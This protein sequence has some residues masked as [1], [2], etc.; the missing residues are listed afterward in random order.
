VC[1]SATFT[2]PSNAEAVTDAVTSRNSASVSIIATFTSAKSGSAPTSNVEA[3]RWSTWFYATKQ[4]FREMIS[5][6]DVSN[7]FIAVQ[8]QDYQ[9]ET[10]LAAYSTLRLEGC[11]SAA[12]GHPEMDIHVYEMRWCDLSSPNNSF[13]RFFMAFY[14]LLL[15][16]TSLGRIAIDQ[17]A[18]EHIGQLDW[19]VFQRT[20][21]YANRFLTV[22]V[23]SLLVVLPVIALAPLVLL[24][25][26]GAAAK[27]VVT[28][29]LC[30]GV[31]GLVVW[32]SQKEKPCFGL[33]RWWPVALVLGPLSIAFSFGIFRIWKTCAPLLLTIEWWVLAMLVLFMIIFPQ[34]DQVRNGALQSGVFLTLAVATG[35]IVC[36]CKY[37]TAPAGLQS[38]SFLMTQYVLV[39]VRFF[40]VLCIAFAMIALAMERICRFR[41]RGHNNKDALARACA[42]ARTGRFTLALASLLLMIITIFLWS[43]IYHYVVPHTH[44]F[45][46]VNPESAH[47][48]S[49]S[50]SSMETDRVI[51]FN[52]GTGCASPALEKPACAL[53]RC[54]GLNCVGVGCTIRTNS[55]TASDRFLDGLL[56]QNAPPGL[57]IVLG[58]GGVG[59]L[60]FILMLIPSVYQEAT[61]PISG[62]NGAAKLLGEWLSS[63]LNALRGVIA[64]FWL[65]AFV[66]PT[67]YFICAVCEY[68]YIH[69]AA[70]EQ[71][72][73]FLYEWRGMAV[74]YSILKSG[75]AFLAGSATILIGLLL[76][77]GSSVLDTILDVDNYLRTS[78]ANNTPRARIVERYLAL[79]HHLHSYRDSQGQS[80]DRIVIVAH[81][82]GSLI[83]ADLFRFLKSSELPTLRKYAL[84][85][86][87]K[88][89]PLYFF[90]MG[91]PLR[92]LLNRFFPNLYRWIRE[93]P[94]GAGE[95]PL[96]PS[97][98]E[99]KLGNDISV[100]ALPAYAAPYAGELGVKLWRNSY[101]SGDYVGRSLWL[102]DW[103]ARTSGADD[104]GTFPGTPLAESFSK[105]PVTCI[106]S[107][108]GLGA[109]TH[110]WDRTAPDIGHELDMLIVI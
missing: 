86:E 30:G 102:N 81:S 91:N 105:I 58:L 29:V 103:Y 54:S 71:F 16:I 108:I 66:V 68:Y 84:A 78:P 6:K 52:S 59:L 14:Q 3:Y 50:L 60:L 46:D 25:A 38:A 20:Y 35:F 65:A 9:G 12:D 57:P 39:G 7:E 94:D 49:F 32:R 79:L 75:G 4:R 93:R 17:A 45:K 95:P 23:F 34:Y 22:G 28:A 85:N 89:L 101:R 53:P 44:L 19:F 42:A 88:S 90:T 77:Y 69:G 97:P 87:K 98:V 33:Y 37:G 2:K 47:L 27:A 43:G 36:V 55:A 21:S 96:P 76:K 74:T 11:R 72:P 106:E 15:H 70:W 82:L 110:Y 40:W 26:N 51:A 61:A 62:A 104:A 109:H 24:L 80:Y 64:I 100:S 67:G 48:R 18:L 31:V 10:R 41:L 73:E 8:L 1:L 5:K 107:C 92:Q 63:G 13:L 99:V 56:F 83:S